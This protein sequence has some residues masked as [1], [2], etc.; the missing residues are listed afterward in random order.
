MTEPQ[1]AR[2]DRNLT[3]AV[4]LR[5][6]GAVIALTA[7]TAAVVVAILLVRSALS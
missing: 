5:L 7:G 1:P 4:R 3:Q 6:L 2:A